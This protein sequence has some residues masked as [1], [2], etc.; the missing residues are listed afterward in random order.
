[1]QRF[2]S[3]TV[4]FRGWLS[5]PG[6]HSKGFYPQS[7][8]IGPSVTFQVAKFKIIHGQMQPA[9][10]D[11]HS[12]FSSMAAKCPL[13]EVLTQDSGVTEELPRETTLCSRCG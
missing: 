12:G 5:P 2:I 8:L 13:T 10:E 7:H 11:P 4:G 9:G 3:S 1:M 6:L